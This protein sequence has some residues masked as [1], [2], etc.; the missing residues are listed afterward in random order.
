[1]TGTGICE[2][3]DAFQAIRRIENADDVKA[4]FDLM[5]E[6]RPHLISADEFAARVERQRGA[7]YC[8]VAAWEDGRPS[9]LAG[10]RIA[11]NL[12]YGRYFYVDDLVTDPKARSQGLG[13]RLMTW[14]KDEARSLNCANFV[15]DTRL[16]NSL[17]QRFYF[18]EGLLAVSL[19]FHVALT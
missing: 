7:G 16:S 8:L 10:Y 15:L 4:C 6:L 2:P 5:R 18:R 1:M 17:G 14:L 13:H 9:A 11:E 19:R 12:V 3:G